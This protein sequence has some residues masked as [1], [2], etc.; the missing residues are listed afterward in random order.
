MIEAKKITGIVTFKIRDRHGN[1]LEEYRK[2]NLIVSSGRSALAA[3]LAGT[4]L[5]KEITQIGFGTSGITPAPE[6]TTLTGAFV[7]DI[8]GYSFPDEKSV[9][10]EWSLDLDEA[11]GLSIEEFGLLCEDD[12]LF[13]RK[14]RAVI[15]KTDALQLTDGSWT[16][17]FE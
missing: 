3:F 9:R 15:E 14:T 2:E 16:I 12:T 1:V 5:D 6:D 11:N 17:I 13:S 10:F 8:T 4:A 7:K